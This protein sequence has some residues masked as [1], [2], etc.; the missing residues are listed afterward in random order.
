[1]AGD[2]ARD[3]EWTK[4]NL[5]ANKKDV[6][7]GEKISAGK[8]NLKATRKDPLGYRSTGLLCES[9]PGVSSATSCCRLQ[10]NKHVGGGRELTTQLLH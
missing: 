9:R 8:K 2:H 1:M 5:E 3:N 4:K 7:Y 10:R 6:N